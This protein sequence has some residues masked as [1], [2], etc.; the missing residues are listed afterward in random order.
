MKTIAL[1]LTFIATHML[2]FVILSAIGSIFSDSF[3]D[4]VTDSG[5]FTIY[6]LVIGW[7]PSISVC[8]ELHEKLYKSN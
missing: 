4:I 1:F 8:H 6:S 2:F 3:T 7:I 5:W